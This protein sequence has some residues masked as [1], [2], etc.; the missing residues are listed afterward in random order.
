[1]SHDWIMA[2]AEAL[3]AE[4]ETAPRL[5]RD[6]VNQPQIHTWL[7]ALGDANPVYR[8]TTEAAEITGGPVAPAAMCQVWTMYGLGLPGED[9]LASRAGD[10]LHRMMGVLDEAGYTSVLGTNADQTYDR[11]LRPGE[12][13]SVSIRMES[14]V[15]PKRTGVGEGYFVTTRSTWR[16]GEEQVGSMSFRVLKFKPRGSGGSGETDLS[17]PSRTVRPTVNRDNAFFFEGLAAGELRIQTCGACGALRHP[18]GPVCPECHAMDRKWVVASGRGVVYSFVEHH[19]PQIPGK[20]LPLL[21]A[22]VELEEGHRM[23]GEL[24]GVSRDDVAIGMP[25]R[26]GFDRIDDDLT[27]A[28]WEPEATVDRSGSGLHELDRRDASEPDRRSSDREEL[29]AWELPLTRTLVVSTALATRDFQDVHHDPALAVQRGTRDIFLNILTTTGL[30][31]RYVTEW[32]GPRAR[33][34]SCALRLGAPAYPGDTLAFTGTVTADEVVEGRRQVAVD[35]VGSVS[36]GAHV[37]ATVVLD[38]GEQR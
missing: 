35:V 16:V 7:E 14:V 2:Q 3:A 29:P 23:I 10:P 30:V 18:P 12:V 1:V 24:R 25:V 17:D 20:T 31:Q 28:Y 34:T 13:P 19:A 26:V 37:T 21:V 8:D 5:A 33:V 22:V 15:G 4:G 11:Y 6:P 38:M 27:L 32:S 9:P 36:L